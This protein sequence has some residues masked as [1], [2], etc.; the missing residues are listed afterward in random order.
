MAEPSA[1]HA[2]DLGDYAALVRRRWR[3]IAGGVVVGLV[4]ACAYVLAAPATYRSSAKVL[5]QPVGNA[6]PTVGQRTDNPV[7]LDTEAQ[8]VTSERVAKRAADLLGSDR[9]SGSDLKGLDPTN[10]ASLARRVDVSV[11]PNTTVLDI[12]FRA[13]TPAAAAAGAEDFAQAYLEDRAQ[14]AQDSLDRDVRR[15]QEQAQ[16][17]SR[18]IQDVNVSLSHVNG[19]AARA[20]RAF[21]LARRSALSS[22]L[23]SY[24]QQLAP[25]VNQQVDP[26]SVI[27]DAQEPRRPVA[28][29]LLLALPA[30]VMLGLL[31]GLG[32]AVWRE[33]SDK[34]IHDRVDIERLYDVAP[35]G[36]VVLPPA[37]EPL[38]D[39]DVTPL[40][41]QLR[42]RG[43]HAET[44]IVVAPDTPQFAERLCFALADAAARSG[45]PTTYVTRPGATTEADREQ[46]AAEHLGLLQLPDYREL[47]VLA[48]RGL[49]PAQL[50]TN[51]AELRSTREFILLGLPSGDLAVDLPVVAPYADVAVVVIRLG[52]SRRDTVFSVLDDLGR[53]G[54]PKVVVVT[55]A[56]DW[57]RAERKRRTVGAEVAPSAEQLDEQPAEQPAEQPEEQPVEQASSEPMV[58][59]PAEAPQTDEPAAAVVVRDRG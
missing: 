28:P 3:W 13:G 58:G 54:V 36:S 21:W 24:N 39:H 18:E 41:H 2:R 57:R 14:V 33:R 48:G 55:A 45:A 15:L 31:I 32:L 30:G 49:R 12:S 38:H 1:A 27:A 53:A 22:E 37:G 50:V 26:G 4:V 5:V 17:V 6:V 29:N 34:R 43:G 9:L 8:L 51:L 46:A 25:I 42:V 44:V 19:R 7:N 35:L 52:V 11:P 23:A 47:G 10:P 40:Y 56:A 59:E 20:D 16:N